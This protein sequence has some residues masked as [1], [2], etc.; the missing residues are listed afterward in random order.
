MLPLADHN[1]RRITPVVNILLIGANVLMFFWEVSLGPGLEPTLVDVA[2]IPARFWYA[3]IH[4][5]NI[6]SVFVSMFL[7]G[8]WLHL[9]GNMLYLWVFGD[10]IEDRLG[11]FKYLIF[12]LLS[13]IAATLAH[14]LANPGSRVPSIGASGAIAGVLGAYIILFP[15][16]RVTTL[17]PIFVFITVR[18]IPAF[19][20]LGFWFVLQLFTGAAVMGAHMSDVGGVAY[21][22][23]IGGF[24]A[25]MVLVI[26]MGGR[27][28]PRPAWYVALLM[29]C[30]CASSG[31][32]QV[33]LDH[34]ILHVQP[35]APERAA[36]ERA[37]FRVAP[38]VNRHEG[39]GTASITFEFENS[40]LELLWPDTDVSV[41]AGLEKAFAKFQNKSNWRTTG[42][43]PITFALHRVGPARPLPVATWSVTAPW[44]DPGTAM[45]MLTPRDDAK[46]PSISIHPHAVS[47]VPALDTMRQSLRAAG[48]LTHPIGVQRITAVRLLAPPQY[49][50]TDAL[51]YLEKERVL[52]LDRSEEWTVELTFDGGAKKKER[53]FRPELPLRIR[54]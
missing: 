29:L 48:A 27:R 1:P 44:M 21:F 17:I 43:C 39:Q 45:E 38:E 33:G 20:L 52:T 8:G 11:H 12:Y 23:H 24:V 51:R 9:G 18:E 40:F 30:A 6:L 14:A 13:G 31:T 19:F 5:L 15:K 34:V 50:P 47:D 26:L 42:A 3:P 22:A 4:P 7:H 49:T 37:G 46:S 25:G 36:L 53:D 35:G 32:R 54:Y 16:Q 28:P 41:N 2:F 10:N